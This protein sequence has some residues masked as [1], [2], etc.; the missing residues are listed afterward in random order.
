MAHQ[1]DPRHEEA[2]RH[3]LK[4]ATPGA[5]FTHAKYPGSHF[6]VVGPGEQ[7]PAGALHEINTGRVM[8]S[9]A[10]MAPYVETGHVQFTGP[11]A[12]SHSSDSH[13][14][15]SLYDTPD[16][17]HDRTP[18]SSAS[19]EGSTTEK[20]TPEEHAT[21]LARWEHIRKDP[22]DPYTEFPE[23]ESPMYGRGGHASRPDESPAPA[24]PPAPEAAAPQ[25]APP[26]AEPAAPQAAPPAPSAT[27]SHA[28]GAGPG[29]SS[30]ADYHGL[31]GLGQAAG[32]AIGGMA[33]PLGSILGMAAGGLLGKAMG[34]GEVTAGEV[35]KTA[36]A[37][38]GGLVGGGAG[39]V[40]GALGGLFG[41]GAEAGG[42][43]GGGGGGA[44]TVSSG[45][46]EGEPGEMVRLLRE[47][48]MNI[49]SMVSDGLFL[50]GDHRRAG[51]SVI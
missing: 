24:A 7:V 41:G 37:A 23:L 38:A 39:K 27:P 5:T 21:Y 36:L 26:A 44:V 17:I 32:Y 46:L 9:V 40:L 22:G 4:H 14:E 11:T 3:F 2:R 25:A 45:G 13:I 8:G 51:G 29:F 16:G 50:K 42:E 19:G 33:G 30:A 20:I 28:P 47:I 31:Q 35:G 12:A 49:K 10:E 15:D 48:S 1:P 43:G 18:G 34:G 6:R